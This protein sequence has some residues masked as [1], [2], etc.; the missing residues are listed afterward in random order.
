MNPV[1]TIEG[2]KKTIFGAGAIQEVGEACKAVRASRALLVMDRDLSK[3]D[4]CSRVQEMLQKSGVKAFLY[5]EVT[6]E[7]APTLADEGAVLARKEKVGC[8]VA[9][10]GGDARLAGLERRRPGGKGGG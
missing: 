3:M 10:G 5:P 2:V 9:V 1:F 4:V 8:V 6:P 7:P